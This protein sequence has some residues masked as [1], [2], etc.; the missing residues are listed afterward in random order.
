[1][2]P[3]AEGD[4][5]RVDACPVRAVWICAACGRAWPCPSRQRQLLAE[6][7]EARV[8]LSLFLSACLVQACVDLATT[9]AGLL[10][11]RFLTW[12]GEMPIDDTDE[13]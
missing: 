12:R 2:P 7:A 11:R 10:Y 13:G 6:Y 3:Y 1:M 5:R 9:P 8:S 4:R